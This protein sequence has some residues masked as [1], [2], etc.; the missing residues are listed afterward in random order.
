MSTQTQMSESERQLNIGIVV[1]LKKLGEVTVRELAL[2]D[3]VKCGQELALLLNVIDFQ[4]QTDGGE[5]LRMIMGE[6]ATFE[7]LKVFAAASCDRK[8]EDF[9]RMSP[10]DWLRLA[11]AIKEQNDWSELQ[12]LF[13]QVGLVEVFL[14]MRQK[15]KTPTK[16]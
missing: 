14:E 10:T 11:V 13:R 12:E 7:A 15:R 9:E 2:E 6:P 8:P 1:P 4:K 5:M 16:T 3:I